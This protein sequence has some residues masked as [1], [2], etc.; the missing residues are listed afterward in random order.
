M[1]YEG[2][3]PEA[4][5]GLRGDGLVK[6][7]EAV[8]NQL[9][10]QFKTYVQSF[11]QLYG[12]PESDGSVIFIGFHN[13]TAGS[14]VD[15][16]F[17]VNYENGIV[18]WCFSLKENASGVRRLALIRA[19]ENALKAARSVGLLDDSIIGASAIIKFGTSESATH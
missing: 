19:G 6:D 8:M 15:Y 11:E 7:S 4:A 16:Y 10:E 5:A 12:K 17:Y 14:G 2:K 18:P 13:E 3:Y 1:I 9:A